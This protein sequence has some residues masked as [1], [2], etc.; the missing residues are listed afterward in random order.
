M[1]HPDEVVIYNT[2]DGKAQVRLQVVGHDAWLTQKQMAQLFDVTTAAI[3]HHIKEVTLSREIGE[4]STFKQLLKVPGQSR[5]VNHYNLDMIIAV[6][7]RVRGPRGSQFRTWAT[8]VLRE[9]L[10]KGF[11][12]DD[13]R[14]KNDNHDTYFDEL[15]E[16]IREIRLSERQFF[17]KI[18]D[19]IAA[20]SSDYNPK[21]TDVQQFFASIQNKLHFAVHGK[22]AAELIIARADAAK[23][24]MGLTNWDSVNGPKTKDVI[25]AK[26]YLTDDELRE[27]ARLTTMYLDYAEDRADKRQGM[28]LSDWKDLTDKWLV[29]NER[30]VLTGA[31]SRSHKQATDYAM[32]QW[33]AHKRTLDAKVDAKDMAALEAAVRDMKNK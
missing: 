2:D 25:V 29:F 16:R 18:C 21:R 33:E 11:A 20:S 1:T 12:L 5:S 26:N 31:G 10:V 6:G 24:N 28:L 23:D 13:Q 3:S 15:L 8:Q 22:T 9:Y 32:E 19:V 27:M 4:E 7:Y 30:E 17:R 14:L